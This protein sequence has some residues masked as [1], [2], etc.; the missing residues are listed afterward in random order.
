MKVLLTGSTGQLGNALIKSMP[1]GIDL[2]ATRRAELDLSIREECYK[3]VLKYQPDWVINSGAFTA[4]DNAEVEEDLATAINS[5]APKTFAEAL[6]QTGGKLLQISTDFVFD[7]KQNVPYKTNQLKKPINVYGKTKAAGEDAIKNVII[8]SYKAV[9][10]RT[11]WLMGPFGKNFLNT[12]LTLHR[13][14]K[15]I[16]VVSDQIGCPTSSLTLANACW[17]T[18]EMH[19]SEEPKSLTPKILHWS[20]SGYASWYEVAKTIGEFAHIKGLIKKP[21]NVLP[22]MTSQYPTPASRPRYSILDCNST[23][24]FLDLPGIHWKDSILNVMEQINS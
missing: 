23:R 19:S 17:K 10:I 18:I 9:I 6:N 8:N 11:G 21:A 14:Q 16:R 4:V 2:I 12:M 15:E 22:I 13:S 7:G 1:T 24:E 3:A 5:I 20:D